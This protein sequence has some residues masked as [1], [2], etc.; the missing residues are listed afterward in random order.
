[1]LMRFLE[2]KRKR[3]WDEIDVTSIE[4]QLYFIRVLKPTYFVPNDNNFLT[5]R[6]IVSFNIHIF[7]FDAVSLWHF[8]DG[9]V[10]IIPCMSTH[11]LNS[12]LVTVFVNNEDLV[13]LY[14][15]IIVIMS[16][17]KHYLLEISHRTEL[18]IFF[19]YLEWGTLMVFCETCD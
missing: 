13:R 17:S 2:F 9:Y 11:S 19:V 5:R 10:L 4:H 15:I 18:I 1:M 16:V 12:A 8:T 7:V 14:F 3:L 6:C